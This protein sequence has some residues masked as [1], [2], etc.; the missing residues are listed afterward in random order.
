ME[1]GAETPTPSTTTLPSRPL[2]SC[3]ASHW[4]KPMKVHLQRN[5]DIVLTG[6]PPGT[7]Q[8][9]AGEGRGTMVQGVGRGEGGA[10]ATE[11]S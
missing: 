4:S 1:Q 3:G 9:R 7:E 11:Y 6:R 10:A 5:P 8:G 2:D